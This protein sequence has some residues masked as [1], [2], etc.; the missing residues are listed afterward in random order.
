MPK[1]K[2]N[3]FSW[4]LLTNVVWVEQPVGAGF[5]TGNVTLTNE[6]E[7]AEQFLGFW[8]NFMKTFAM[9]GW[10]VYITGESYGGIYEPF[11]ANHMISAD[12]KDYY[13]MS[14]MLIYDGIMF[15]DEVQG[16]IPSYEYVKH[17]RDLL[18]YADPAREK[19]KHTA[20]KCGFTDFIEK[21]WQYPPS[22]PMPHLTPGLKM[23]PNGSRQYEDQ[24]CASFF[25][26]VWM[27]SLKVNPC[28]NIYNIMDRCPER[29]DVL[30]GDDR[31]FDRTDVKKAINA[32]VDRVWKQCR[33]VF[34]EPGDQS[35]PTGPKVLPRVINKTKNVI[36]AHGSFDYILTADGMLMGL[37]NMTWGCNL[38]LQKR[39]S[40]P[41]YVPY[42]GYNSVENY[43]DDPLYAKEL[44]AGWGVLGTTH[45][46]RG[47]TV[48]LTQLAGHEG[49][50]YLPA[51]AWRILEKLL[52]RV[53]N[54]SEKSSFSYPPIANFTQPAGELGNGTFVIPC[55]GPNC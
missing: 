8:K 43:F 39:P 4:H 30:S 28:F 36:L 46:E 17:H 11:I 34:V 51:A 42:Y 1:P 24:D 18:P 15:D 21:Y 13:D 26:D 25:Y 2:P 16:N 38:G 53:D 14:G 55:Y 12:D 5:S 48:V 29:D 27:E 3:P 23:F 19:M 45:E 20:D 35:G 37:Q 33:T 9:Q 41:F 22:G 47:L 10:K 31:Y 7:L 52:G 44:P 49:P 40:A 54:L 50:E 32:P 6:D